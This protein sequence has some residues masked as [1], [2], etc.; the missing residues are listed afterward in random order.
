ML[1]SGKT[2]VERKDVRI[3]VT[4]QPDLDAETTYIELD[5]QNEENVLYEDIENRNRG[6]VVVQEDDI[7]EYGDQDNHVDQSHDASCNEQEVNIHLE[8][9]ADYNHGT[10]EIDLNALTYN[11]DLRRTES[12]IAGQ[13]PIGYGFG[14]IHLM[15]YTSIYEKELATSYR[16][17]ISRE[18]DYQCIDAMKFEL[19]T[20]ENWIFGI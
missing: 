8:S 3:N 6:G 10:L 19:S 2:I 7:M 16:E 5:L 9:T 15:M 12:S 18:E 11:P 4:A 13:K 17:S 1:S 14:E 20:L